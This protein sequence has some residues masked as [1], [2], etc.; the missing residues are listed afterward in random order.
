MRPDT[1][2]NGR[3]VVVRPLGEGGMGSVCL[4]RDRAQG[5]RE[6]ALKL[7][8]PDTLDPESAE[9]FKNEFR[10]MTRLSHP[11]LAEVYDFGTTSGNGRHFLTMEYIRGND[12]T[13]WRWPVIRGRVEDLVVQCLR[14]LD[15]I[16]A[17]GLLHNDIKPQNILV[18]EPFQVKLLDFGLAQR[19]SDPSDPGLSGTIHYL[20]PERLQGNR[21]DLRSDLYALGIV[22]YELLAGAPPYQAGDEGGVVA[23]ILRGHPHAPRA[24]N[25]DLPPHLE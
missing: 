6:V 16:H 3:Y 15:Y 10:S 12:L 20:A 22:L 11:N 4:V 1:V 7:L 13:A 21:P 25:P 9:R 24:L 18:R 2:V 19:L 5:G 23:S 17:R 8:R 14:A